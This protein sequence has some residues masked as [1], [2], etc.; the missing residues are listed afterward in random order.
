MIGLASRRYVYRLWRPANGQC[1]DFLPLRLNY[2]LPGSTRRMPGQ[3]ITLPVRVGLQGTRLMIRVAEGVSDR[4]LGV[5]LR[6]AG[7]ILGARPRRQPKPSTPRPSPQPEY[8]PSP[9]SASGTHPHPAGG[10]GA[11]ELASERLEREGLITTPPRTRAESEPPHVSEEQELV[12]E[13]ADPGAE[14]GAGAA[15]SV[16]EPW[17]GYA[18]MNARTVISRLAQ[19]TKAEL[20]AVELYER[21]HRGRRTVLEAAERELRTSGR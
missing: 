2:E 20:A 5:T 1:T 7:A 21:A 4:A 13:S 8:R 19:A 15:V 9:E 6:V 3:L 11:G 17:E 10:N 14:E 16:R 18:R 12:L